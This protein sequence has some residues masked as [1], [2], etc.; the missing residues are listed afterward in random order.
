[1]AIHAVRAPLEPARLYLVR[2]DLADDVHSRFDRRLSF[3]GAIARRAMSFSVPP[4]DAGGYA[5]A[6]WSR[7][8]K[9]V[10]QKPSGA[11]L[12]I[13]AAATCPVTLPNRS[14]PPGQPH[15]VAWYGNGLLW[16]G[17]SRDGIYAVPPDQVGADGSIGNKLLWATTPASSKPAVS[18]ERLDGAAPPLRVLRREPWLVRGRRQA[19]V[20]EP[21]H[22][23]HGRLLA[24]QGAARRHQPDVRRQRHRSLT[25]SR[26]PARPVWVSRTATMGRTALAA[27]ASPRQPRGV[28]AEARRVG[29]V[30][31]LVF[32]L[33]L[34]VHVAV[35][36]RPASARVIS[37][38]SGTGSWVSIY[39]TGAWRNPER[40]IDKLLAHRVHTLYLQTS[41]YRQTVDVVKPARLG[42]FLDAADAAG[43]DV[44]GWYLPSLASPSRDLRRALA[45]ARFRSAAGNGFDGFALD[46]EATKV[47]SFA[48]RNRRA[49]SFAASVRRALGPAYPLGAITLAPVGNSPSYWPNYPY[50][51][52]A[53]HVDVVLPMTYFT[54]R[55]DG[56]ANVSRY[57]AAS[58]TIIRSQ[59]G[60]SFPLHPIGGE[61]RHAPL[62]EVK[63]FLRT[64]ALARTVGTS[65]WEYGEMTPAQWSALAA[66]A[67]R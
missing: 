66:V 64:V 3:V 41:N 15:N 47:R 2:R 55:A 28:R 56:P 58:L 51:K 13:Q 6:Y 34:C 61:A 16:A 63:A 1:M 17:L 44:V 62:A 50:R 53:A 42:R 59:I 5:L 10:V 12:H 30:A 24:H 33:A 20:H 31:A 36:A 60:L 65:M 4:L 25:T 32:A 57:T 40:V 9:L 35:A 43:I 67:S 45:G 22:L 29:P 38:Y 26:Y 19:L 14:R 21:G 46:I 8:R 48:L 18:G 54:A 37:P 52:I 49:I 7:G 39:D 11:L 23:P 27:P